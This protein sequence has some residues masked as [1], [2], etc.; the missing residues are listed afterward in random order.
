[1]G[2]YSRLSTFDRCF[3]DIE[4]GNTHMHV[5]GTCVFDATPVA[6]SNGGVDID[7]IRRY[8]HGRLSSIPRYRQRLAYIPLENHPVWVD[9]YRFDLRYHVRH[10]SLPKPGDDRQ[11]KR[12]LAW[13]NSQQLDRSRPLWEMW[14][15]EGLEGSRFAVHQ[16]VHHAMIDGLAGAEELSV[17][18]DLSPEA[19]VDFPR[20]WQPRPAPTPVELVRDA[21]VRRMTTPIALGRAVAKTFSQGLRTGAENIKRTASGIGAVVSSGWKPAADT[22]LNRPIGS[23]RRFDTLATDLADVKAVKERL[24]GTINDVVLA[25]V[26]GAMRRYMLHDGSSSEELGELT[27]RAMCPVN[28]RSEEGRSTVG[29]KVAGMMVELPIGESDPRERYSIVRLASASAKRSNQPDGTEAIGTLSEWTS[30][31]LLRLVEQVAPRHRVY[32]LIVT[33]IP[34]PP[35]PLYLLGA[36]ML[37]TYALVP[38][39]PNQ[40]LAVALFSYAGTLHWGFNADRELVPDL[41][42]FVLG[43]QD[44]FDELAD[45]AKVVR[46]QPAAASPTPVAAVGDAT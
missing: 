15:I 31:H 23:Q 41:H 39:F 6:T 12:A 11:L 17:I 13:V 38:L 42:D 5:A 8:V 25:T 46:R 36:R 27:L 24:G 4:D 32:N 30:P 14:I 10:L 20:P 21:A 9:D 35:F 37:E 2:D 3:L 29:N 43:V 19:R 26:A 18:L 16:K 45:A 44:S 33:N 22:R 28:R 34:G 1:M 40:G 7:R